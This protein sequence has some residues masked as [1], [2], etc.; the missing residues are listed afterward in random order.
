MENLQN[1]SIWPGSIVY[2]ERDINLPYFLYTLFTLPTK[3]LFNPL[4]IS[5][6]GQQFPEKFPQVLHFKQSLFKILRLHSSHC[7][8]S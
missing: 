2:T 1:E 5:N 8:L 4:M 7:N 6:I 3:Y